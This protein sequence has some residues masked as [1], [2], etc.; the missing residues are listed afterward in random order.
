MRWFVEWWYNVDMGERITMTER[1][2]LAA[3]IERLP[4]DRLP[5]ALE[6]LEPLVE[7][8]EPSRPLEPEVTEFDIRDAPA[9]KVRVPLRVRARQPREKVVMEVGLPSEANLATLNALNANARWWRDH[10]AEVI[11]AYHNTHIAISQGEVFT[12]TSYFD[13]LALASA[14]HPDN[15]AFVI[16]L[17]NS[18]PT[19]GNASGH[20]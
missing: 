15:A 12:G 9:R 18:L 13:A 5:L 8:I 16:R 7:A 14:S 1:E 19:N 10:Y 17:F 2:Q 6:R 4:A 3:L 20:F 11:A